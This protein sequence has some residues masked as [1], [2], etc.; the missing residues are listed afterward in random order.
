[1]LTYELVAYL[2]EP[3][4]KKIKVSTV[5]SNIQFNPLDVKLEKFTESEI[6]EYVKNH[7]FP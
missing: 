7:S 2:E 5:V 3:K 1:M 4:P 6:K